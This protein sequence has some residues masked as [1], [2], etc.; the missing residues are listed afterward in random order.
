M[1]GGAAGTVSRGFISQESCD[2]VRIMSEFKDQ[3]RRAS[4]LLFVVCRWSFAVCAALA[5]AFL[6]AKTPPA[7]ACPFCSA[8][9]QTL[10]EEQQSADAVVLAKLSQ[11][12][13]GKTAE[14][15]FSITN[16]ETGTAKFEIIEVLRGKERLN[17]VKEIDVVFFG[18]PTADQVFS[19][20][21]IGEEKLD[22]TTP[23]PLTPAAVDY[24]RKLSEVP[25]TGADRLD[26]FQQY[27]ENEDPLLAQD[28][29]DEFARAPYKDVQDLRERMH[30]DDLV[31]WI[32]DPAVNPSR[33]RLYLTMLGVCGGKD[34]LPLL[35]EMITSDYEQQRP[36]VE[37][38]V[39]TGLALHGPLLLPVWA[40]ALK[41]DERRKK[42]GLDA[43][44][45]CYLTLRGPEGLD[46]IDE[47][48]L[49]KPKVEYTY[50][51]STI[52][53]L[54]FHGDEKTGVI[55]QERLLASMR[56]LLDDPDFA[57]QVI[58]DL[59]RWEDWEVMDRLVE[60]F[61]TADKAGFIRQPIVTYLTVAGEEPGEVGERAKK[62]LAELESLDP[63]AVKKAKSLMAFGFAARARSGNNAASET[64]TNETSGAATPA[65][66][67]AGQSTDATGG[68]AASATDASSDTDASQIP[69]PAT[70]G[71][72]SATN[73]T[74]DD[75][76]SVT[77]EEQP[78]VS[79][80][81]SAAEPVAADS[82]PATAVE[83]PAH[84]TAKPVTP[85]V[86]QTSPTP[87][88][89]TTP[90]ATASPSVVEPNRLLIIGVPLTAAVMLVGVY[91]L[92]LRS[93]AV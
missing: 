51:Y 82:P 26:F 80:A 8:A 46:L 92:I 21:A 28:S 77:T 50:K 44:V 81:K 54:R 58:I 61:K 35:E 19:I 66:S 33:R 36:F 64:A 15:G 1:A 83:K 85:V 75:P 53:A 55:P 91:W 2:E 31:K 23:L 34:D 52:M 86:A 17:D 18:E 38:A 3:K 93:G 11:P 65:D 29:Y 4:L 78:A 67:V 37:G 42:L 63:E 60:M 87:T 32:A 41:T 45:A 40:E 72:A 12:P 14:G 27:L 22:W 43:L 47:R 79:E 48:F 69:D 39:Q 71:D 49:K 90:S 20:S 16:P 56:L 24:V 62:S 13:A 7:S 25:P 59:S 30:H 76:A 84:E 74:T 68:F 88:A 89:A 70:F 57:D 73:R 6:L 10:S 9:S 5:L